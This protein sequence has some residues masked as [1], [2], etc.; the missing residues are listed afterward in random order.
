MLIKPFTGTVAANGIVVVNITHGLHGIMWKVYQIGFGLGI[1]APSPQV[2]AHVNG[3]PLTATVTMQSSAFAQA[4]AGQQPP[5]AME[6]FMVGPPYI[7]L[8]AGDV[9]ACIVLGAVS[10]DTFTAGAYIDEL[11]SGMAQSMG[12]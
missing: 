10:G 4:P 12:T 6:T 1:A 2:A 11:S 5:Y 7:Y 3:I 8:Q 9:I